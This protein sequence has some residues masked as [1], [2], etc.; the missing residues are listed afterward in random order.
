MSKKYILL[1][2]LFAVAMFLAVSGKFDQ[3][4]TNAA[5]KTTIEGSS[6]AQVAKWEI[7]KIEEAGAGIEMTAGMVK[8]ENGSVGNWFFEVSNKSQTNAE[9]CEDITIEV[10]LIS[11]VFSTESYNSSS[12][13]TWDYLTGKDNPITFKV[14]VY[15]ETTMS[16]LVEYKN[17]DTSSVISYDAYKLIVDKASYTE[18]IKTGKSTVPPVLDT[19]LVSGTTS[20]TN[21]KLGTEFVEDKLVHY[22]SQ[23]LT[24]KKELLEKF[25]MGNDAKSKIFR[26]EWSVKD[27]TSSSTGQSKMYKVYTDA[28]TYK[29]YELFDYL[30]YLSS[31]KGEP[32]FNFTSPTGGTMQVKASKLTDEQYNQL[33]EFE[34][35]NIA[36][37]KQFKTDYNQY[38]DSLGYLEA[39]LTCSFKFNI[40]VGQGE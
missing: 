22:L 39:G 6:T 8:V 35:L 20:V 36:E 17:K 2:C 3:S 10:K 23:T 38:L 1:L 14:Y 34:K 24:I 31:I 29:E 9:I 13:Y 30:K 27:E 21:L 4:V 16:E 26:I 37:W 18:E 15:D 5:Y 32:S 11:D 19:S 28:T 7:S 33:E 12:T 40:K 25:G